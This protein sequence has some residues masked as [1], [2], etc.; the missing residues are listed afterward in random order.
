MTD[1]FRVKVTAD[2]TQTESDIDQ[3]INKIENRKITLNVEVGKDQAKKL[4]S[5][6]EKGLKSTKI[7]ETLL[8]V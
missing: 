4:A 6:I 1:D 7:Y 8:K 2:T 5:N 3:L